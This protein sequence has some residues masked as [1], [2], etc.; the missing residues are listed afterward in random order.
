MEVA[1]IPA[2]KELVRMNLGV[3]VLAPWAAEAEL[4]RGSLRM[5]PVGTKALRRRWVMAHL[6]GRPLALAEERFFK[7][8]RAQAT[9][10]RKVRK[11]LPAAPRA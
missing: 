7:L 11:D 9:G 3:A 4:A 5:R 8:C 10:L 6:A 2:I 1:S